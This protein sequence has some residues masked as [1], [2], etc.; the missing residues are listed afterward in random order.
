M[1]RSKL[2]KQ[3]EAQERSSLRAKR[4]HNDQLA[5]LDSRLGK[6]QGAKKERSRL[7][8][9]L[10]KPKDKEEESSKP[11]KKRKAKETKD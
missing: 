2:E 4:S 6:D 1:R 9:L 11:K 8:L 7:K 10:E 3:K 5:V